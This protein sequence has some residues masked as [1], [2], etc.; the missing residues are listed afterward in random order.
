[1]FWAAKFHEALPAILED[2][3]E[4]RFLYLVLTVKNCPITELRD[5]LRHM[6]ESW[7][8][9]LKRPVFKHVI[10][11][12][13]TTE[14]TKG[15]DDSAHPHFNVLLFVQPGYFAGKNYLSQ[16]KWTELWRDVARLDYDPMVWIRAVK[17][18]K[19]KGLP[20]IVEPDPAAGAVAGAKE[21]MKY[22]VKPADLIQSPPWLYELTR[23]THHLRF[24]ASGGCFKNAF[25]QEPTD[26]DLLHAGESPTP[27]PAVEE[28]SRFLWKDS[29][30]RYAF[31]RKVPASHDV[32]LADRI[33][34]KTA[35]QKLLKLKKD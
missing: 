24:L 25:R 19:K 1:M 14:V 26:E 23:Q 5:M 31:E 9:M 27:E 7:R 17:A 30:R 12:I 15:K 6:N 21:V 29:V 28:L 32:P 2:H 13:R 35:I 3:P 4:G 20:G 18:K 11:W 33:K 22:S 8:R 34:A 16:D 10:G